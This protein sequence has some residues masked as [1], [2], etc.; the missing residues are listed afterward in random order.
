[1]FVLLVFI[2]F[3]SFRFGLVFR[4]GFRLRLGLG[5]QFLQYVEILG[6]LGEV[7]LGQRH[8][9]LGHQSLQQLHLGTLVSHGLLVG[10]DQ[11][12]QLFHHLRF[13]LVSLGFLLQSRCLRLGALF[14]LSRLGLL[15]A[16]LAIA[17]AA[18]FGDFQLLHLWQDVVPKVTHCTHGC[19]PSRK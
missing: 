10:P 5:Q 16:V 8:L 2:F 3:F 1:G 15:L 14:L 7:S 17:R 9:D 6:G 4:F 18:R 12:F 13:V 19:F 11:R